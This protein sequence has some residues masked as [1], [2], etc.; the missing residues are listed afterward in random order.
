LTAQVLGVV[1][2]ATDWRADL[3]N[4]IRKAFRRTP[5]LLVQTIGEGQFGLGI[6]GKSTPANLNSSRRRWTRRTAE[7]VVAGFH[8][9]PNRP[10][11]FQLVYGTF[12]P[13]GSKEKYLYR[14]LY[15]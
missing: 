6:D 1:G 4:K 3:H 2:T 15:R 7:F 11:E 8:E 9:R 5:I 13:S 12:V 10:S 14:K